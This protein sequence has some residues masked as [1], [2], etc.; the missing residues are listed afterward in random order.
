[1]FSDFSIVSIFT[2]IGAIAA[3]FV[4]LI[5]LIFRRK[6]H[7]QLDIVLD[8]C[9]FL[10][11]QLAGDLKNFS[12]VIDGEPASEQIVWVTGWII[13]SGH[14]DISERIIEAPLRLKTPEDTQW[15]RGTIEHCSENVQCS[16]N[17]VGTDVLQFD[18]T[19][20]RTGEYIRFEALLNCPLDK[21]QEDW[22]MDALVET[23]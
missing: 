5:G 20:L 17:I 8:K 6:E 9:V 10:V 16:S 4:P 7:R 11:N 13:N 23:I 15:L 3:I 14:F 19:L 12:I 1:M 2:I 21:I 18:W 22:G